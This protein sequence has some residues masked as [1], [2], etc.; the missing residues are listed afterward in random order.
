MG[1]ELAKAWVKV[2]AD[3]SRLKGDLGA[4]RSKVTSSVRSMV[5]AINPILATI[6][7]GAG[8]AGFTQLL[9]AGEDFN[10]KMRG[11]LA[12]MGDVSEAMRSEMKQAALEAARSTVYGAGQAAE[13]YFFLA[14][15]GLDAQQSIAAM[16][17]VAMFAQAGMFDLARATDLATDAQSALGLTVK[18]SQQNLENMKRVTDVLVKANTLANAS[19]EQF[20]MSITNKAGAAARVVGKDIEELTAVLAAFADQG[21]KGAEAGSAINIILRDLQTAVR[22]NKGAFDE[23]GVAVYDAAGN[24]RNMADI[25]GELEKALAGMS[26]E[27]KKTTLAQMGFADRSMIFIQTLLGTS[28]KIRTYEKELRSAGGT[29]KMVA[30]KQ[31]TPLQRVVAKLGVAFVGLSASLMK[32][33]GPAFEA[34]MKGAIGL[35]RFFAALPGLIQKVIATLAGLTAAFYIA[36]VAVK[37]FGISLKV[38]LVGTGIGIA[39][40]AIGMGVEVLVKHFN[41]VPSAA[42]EVK[43]AMVEMKEAM[44]IAE[45]AV[46]KTGEAVEKLGEKTRN[47][48]MEAMKYRIEMLKAHV[49]TALSVVGIKYEEAK[50]GRAPEW[51]VY[52]A[53]KAV[54]KEKKKALESAERELQVMLVG[55]HVR[56]MSRDLG[57]AMG[58]GQEHLFGWIWKGVNKIKEMLAKYKEIYQEVKKLGEAERERQETAKS[59]TESLLTPLERYKKEIFEIE[60][61]RKELGPE[62]YGRAR[63][64]AREE[65]LRAQE[66]PAEIPEPPFMAAGRV[67]FADFG[68]RIQDALLQRDDPQKK[69]LEE[70][71]K[72]TVWQEKA[73]AWLEKLFRKPP[74]MQLA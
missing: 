62:M 20:S 70:L 24:M 23:H 67:G 69:S 50:K 57:V 28:K 74:T 49:G 34:I 73:D 2:R 48:T 5:S 16:P 47:S 10:R 25:M 45:G 65:Y 72:Q 42:E 21:V 58:K 17:Q 46:E 66:K 36:K 13:S 43:K 6:G 59:I 4:T 26:D 37:L 31:M 14:S 27:T 15:A 8:L 51:E 54:W 19:V 41:K 29:T 38:A 52:E 71:E 63:E 22:N 1:L 9:R 11:S 64:R 56:K 40:V 33:L 3:S 44:L 35:I 39:L 32:S 68:Q 53:A 60:R 18:D 61:L 12:I 55:T 30:D 7:V